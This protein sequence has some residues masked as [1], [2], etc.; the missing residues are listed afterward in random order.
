MKVMPPLG[1]R[2]KVSLGIVLASCVLAAAIHWCMFIV[3][4]T[5]L[6]MY[7]VSARAD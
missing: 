5:V 6:F 1:K 3:G 2:S 4:G 7:L